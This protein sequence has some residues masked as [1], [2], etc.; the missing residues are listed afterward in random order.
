MWPIT[1]TFRAALAS[2]VHTMTVK[3]Q[4]LDTDFNVVEGGEFYDTG[5]EKYIQNYIVDGTVSGDITRATRRTLQLS[6]LNQNAQF[7]PNSAWGGLFYVNR[8]IRVFRGIRFGDYE[9]YVPV[10]TFMIDSADV[11][12][13]RNM[14]VVAITGSDLWKKFAKA[15]FGVPVKYTAG[16]TLNTVIK[17]MA[18]KA[19]VTSYVLDTLDGRTSNSTTLQADHNYEMADEIGQALLTLGTDFGL[20]IYF[21]PLGRLV[22][23]DMRT[24][25]DTAVV[26]TY[27]TAQDESLL[28]AKASYSDDL[29][30]NHIVVT[31]TADQSNVIHSVYKDTNPSSPT[32]VN[33]IG[34][35]TY[36]YESSLIKTQEQADAT[37]LKLFLTHVVT[38]EDVELQAIC[39]P[40]FEGNDMVAVRE[41]D[42]TK[43]NSSY[44]MRT[45]EVPLSTS[46]QDMTLQRA[47]TV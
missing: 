34:L 40:A 14:S 3:A 17:D 29:L 41:G 1:P 33:R 45:F 11:V 27:D 16:T 19:G 5:S 24:I 31:G 35:R 46:R 6:I 38:T 25:T 44:R 37:A 30:Y 28:M 18:S 13:E 4:V 43:L 47:V 26:W 15:K 9:E 8:L 12:A 21:D 23:R 2:P 10:G 20:D 32:N 39:N 42:Y 22:T 7:S 36:R